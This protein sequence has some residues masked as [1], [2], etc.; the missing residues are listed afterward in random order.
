VAKINLYFECSG[1]KEGCQWRENEKDFSPQRAQ[2]TR[3]NFNINGTKSRPR[4]LKSEG[5]F[6][7]ILL[8]LIFS[9]F[10]VLSVV[11]KIRGSRTPASP[12]ESR[13]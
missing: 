3:R 9:V 11:K 8:I 7:V 1:R 13:V 5:D 12:F 2:R 10:S 6:S 4:I